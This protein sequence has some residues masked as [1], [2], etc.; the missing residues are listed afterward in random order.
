MQPN[1]AS[2]NLL[3]TPEPILTSLM[4]S[5]LILLSIFVAWVKMVFRYF[6]PN[7]FLLAI[8]NNRFTTS[9]E[10]T[11]E[12]FISTTTSKVQSVMNYVND[13][14]DFAI[15]WMANIQSFWTAISPFV[16]F[17]L[18]CISSLFQFVINHF[19]ISP[20]ATISWF[21]V[22]NFTCRLFIRTTFPFP[23]FKPR[24]PTSKPAASVYV[25]LCVTPDAWTKDSSAFHPTPR[26]ISKVHIPFHQ[27][28]FNA[29]HTFYRSF[30]A[31][32]SS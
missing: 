29:V 8:A 16:S 28:I 20:L 15:P 2:Q 26:P 23:Y 10:N 25:L 1:S 24:K 9:D 30:Q 18:G 7:H 6:F 31:I 32:L 14:T 27:N 4:S 19:Q 21:V 5:P 11:L 12:Y 13:S 17:V 22:W 3:M